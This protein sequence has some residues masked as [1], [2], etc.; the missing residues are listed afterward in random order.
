MRPAVDQRGLAHGALTAGVLFAVYLFC[1][2]V[3]AWAQ[4]SL[5]SEN[6]LWSGLA[7]YGIALATDTTEMNR[8]TRDRYGIRPVPA[9][10]VE[11][12]VDEGA[13]EKASRAY[14]NHVGSEG[15]L[16]PVIV[17][18]VGTRYI[19]LDPEFRIPTS[20]FL[21]HLILDQDFQVVAVFAA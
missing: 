9:S 11:R 15:P 13:C 7:S 17:I 18:R 14:G 3:P 16:Q 10:E 12:V 6:P 5:C 19:V 4:E 8:R 2:P 1:S 21:P 20:E